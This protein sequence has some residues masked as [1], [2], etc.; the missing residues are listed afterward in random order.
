MTVLLQEMYRHCKALGAWGNGT[1][2][3][4]AAGVPTGAPGIVT[5]AKAND[6]LVAML[7]EALGKHRAW[8]RAALALDTGAQSAR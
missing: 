8:D 6:D 7:V 1:N 2:I 5:G 4:E 3:L